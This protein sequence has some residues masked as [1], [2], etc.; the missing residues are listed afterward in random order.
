VYPKFNP[1][2][3]VIFSPERA[4]ALGDPEM[5]PTTFYLVSVTAD[6]GSTF[7]FEIIDSGPCAL[8]EALAISA[9]FKGQRVWHPSNP[10]KDSNR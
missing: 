4:A 2:D 3:F 5:P 1:Q 10:S 9:C 6:K 8:L 7:D